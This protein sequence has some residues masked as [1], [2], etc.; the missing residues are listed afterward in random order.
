MRS[1][2]KNPESQP[3][4]PDSTD[5][6]TLEQRREKNRA[7]KQTMILELLTGRTILA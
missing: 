5:L 1:Q 6:V 2:L 7:L 3:T 4:A